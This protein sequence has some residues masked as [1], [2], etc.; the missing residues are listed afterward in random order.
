MPLELLPLA[1]G[2][3]AFLHTTSEDELHIGLRF[4]I[5]QEVQLAA[6]EP[7]LGQFVFHG[8]AVIGEEA[9]VR[10]NGFYT[11]GINVKATITE[12]RRQSSL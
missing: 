3:E 2:A 4:V 6:V 12:I 1:D 8:D 11:V 10:E 5:N 9:A 7:C